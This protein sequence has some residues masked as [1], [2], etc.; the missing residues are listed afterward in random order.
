MSSTEF[1]GSLWSIT[2]CRFF[3]SS[4]LR[5]RPPILP[6]ARAAARPARVRSR[7]MSRSNSARAPKT[8]KTSL[9][10]EEVLQRPPEAVEL[11]DHELIA[12]P[13]IGQGPLQA[14]PLGPGPAGL[15]GVDLL[16]ARGLQG[17]LL[18]VE[19]L[20]DGRDPGVSDPHR[21]GP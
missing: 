17:I 4:R 11:P 15:V 16:A 14:G 20:L 13:Q 6:R 8:W 3:L 18:E 2:A 12:G 9:P 1:V 10:L 5:G 21:T 7:M 19:I